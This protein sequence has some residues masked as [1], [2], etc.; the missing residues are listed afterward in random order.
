M[1]IKTK[2]FKIHF[3]VLFYIF[4]FIIRIF[5][6]D[7]FGS[8]EN[9]H[10]SQ[11]VLGS[12]IWVLIK[13]TYWFIP[14]FIYLLLN[15]NFINFFKEK[16]T[17]N[18]KPSYSLLFLPLWFIVLFAEAHFKIPKASLTYFYIV[19]SVIAAPFIEEFV[20]R[21]FIFSKLLEKF[22]FIKANM[23]QSLLFAC[24]HLPYYY[25][26]GKFSHLPLLV[27]N[28]IYLAFFAFISGYLTKSTKSLYPSILL[29]AINN[30]LV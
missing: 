20:F 11:G 25:E 29:H 8:W 3:V 1:D 2:K 7:I 22:S 15:N 16:L 13:L 9:T 4:L 18:I 10:I 14:I 17:F 30:L 19:N 27:G 23:L 24:I 12:W 26:L 5:D 21:G 28:L 6:N